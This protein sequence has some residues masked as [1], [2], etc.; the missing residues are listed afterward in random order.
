MPP[1]DDLRAAGE[2]NMQGILAKL[3]KRHRA[4]VQAQIE[5]YGR[6][7]DIP[8]E[9]WTELQREIEDE[10]VAAVMLLILA[11]DEWT[12]E[13]V[14][15]QGVTKRRRASQTDA[16]LSAAQQVQRT[17]AQT[18][19]TLRNRLGRRIEDAKASG[20]GDVGELT[21][22]GI[23]QALDDV[24]TQDRR[25]TIA[26]DQTTTAFSTGQRDAAERIGRG[27]ITN[28][29]GQRVT[30]ELTWRTERDNRVCPRCSPLEGQ[31]ESVWSQV[32]PEGPGPTAHP[33]CRCFLQPQVI[34]E[35]DS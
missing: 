19:D 8:E 22:E 35:E 14:R 9:F 26:A 29:V 21:D 34:V 10:Q 23:D 28:E 31:P 30:L 17:A 5:R 18:V 3:D 20:P 25:A 33:N 27:G 6:V 12:T 13:E 11:A 16:A 4:R 15:Q 32:F 1:I 24:F 7:Q 2:K